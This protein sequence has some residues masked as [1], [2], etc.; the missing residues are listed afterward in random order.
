MNGAGY[1][2]ALVTSAMLFAFPRR[3]APIS[4]LCAAAYVPF[5]QVIEIGFLH[6]PVIRILITLGFVRVLLKGEHISGK[7]NAL[8]WMM[9]LWALWLVF[10]SLFHESGVLITQLGEVF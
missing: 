5:S 3:W 6:F 1:L 9:I 2:F 7:L 8:D 10:I 4:F